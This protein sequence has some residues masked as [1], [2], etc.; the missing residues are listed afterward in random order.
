VTA[1]LAPQ[2]FGILYGFIYIGCLKYMPLSI[3]VIFVGCKTVTWGPLEIVF[4]F[5]FGEDT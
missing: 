3:I 2:G 4:S 1:A 5:P